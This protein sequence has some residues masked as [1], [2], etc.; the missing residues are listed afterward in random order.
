[1]LICLLR[2]TTISGI[3]HTTAA[4]AT[5][6]IPL[7]WNARTCVK[8]YAAR[9]VLRGWILSEQRPRMPF[10]AP[11]NNGHTTRVHPS[12]FVVSVL[13][14]VVVVWDHSLKL[15][16]NWCLI[17][18]IVLWYTLALIDDIGAIVPSSPTLLPSS[19]DIGRDRTLLPPRLILFVIVP[20][21]PP[22]MI[23]FVIVP[24]YPPQLILF[25]IVPSSPPRL[26]LLL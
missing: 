20:S 23:L 4:A 24:S 9:P 13:V 14:L 16:L 22:R 19:N 8:R 2:L 17:I 25:V 5:T 15:H 1:M 10:R 18:Y 21:Y 7:E 3:V 26:L 12:S 6:I 11:S